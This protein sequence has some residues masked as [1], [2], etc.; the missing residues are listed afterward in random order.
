MKMATGTTTPLPIW[1]AL[2]QQ[3]M[4]QGMP[5]SIEH[6]NNW[7]ISP[8]S[9]NGQNPG[10]V[11][12]KGE[13][14]IGNMLARLGCLG[15]I[16]STLARSAVS[17]TVRAPVVPPTG[18]AHSC[19]PGEPGPHRDGES[20]S[21]RSVCT[22]DT[23]S[24][25]KRSVCG[26]APVRVRYIQGL[27]E[28]QSVYNLT[29]ADAHDFYAD[30]ILVHNCDAVAGAVEQLYRTRPDLEITR[31]DGAARFAGGAGGW[32]AQRVAPRRA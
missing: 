32:Q 7:R 18:F 6:R 29:V 31:L 10:I 2:P 16:P 15:S 25:P 26:S 19:A 28:P 4:A 27:A 8:T 13:H 17:P 30:G 20:T 14:G 1:Y 9:R 12:M 5:H 24:W 22:V 11:P 21:L 3:S 23:L